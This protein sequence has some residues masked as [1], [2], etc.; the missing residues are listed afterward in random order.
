M[1]STGRAGSESIELQADNLASLS[2]IPISGMQK[3]SLSKL[4]RI[5]VSGV[6]QCMTGTELDLQVIAHYSTGLY[7]DVTNQAKYAG[8]D[9][10][11]AGLQDVTITYEEDGISVS[12]TVQIEMLAPETEPPT[13][14]ATEIATEAPALPATEMP[15]Q[16]AAAEPTPVKN[17][18][19]L[20]IAAVAVLILLVIIECIIIKKLVRIRKLRKAAKAAAKEEA[21]ALPDD[22]SPLEYV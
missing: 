14:P 12:S 18:D 3:P 9:L 13:Q 1:L 6:T 15:T 10:A 11:A 5:S 8:I 2:K 7:R 22:N 4:D 21:A 19:R 20:W 17:P 16:P